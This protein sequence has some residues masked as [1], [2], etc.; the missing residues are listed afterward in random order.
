MHLLENHSPSE[1]GSRIK[2]LLSL[3]L[4]GMEN[5]DDDML[6]LL[7][8]TQFEEGV[9]HIK[10]GFNKV[11]SSLK[12]KQANP[13]RNDM[14]AMSAPGKAVYNSELNND[15]DCE[16]EDVTI[17]FRLHT[18]LPYP[19]SEAEW[20][21]IPK[22][23]TSPSTDKHICPLF[24]EPFRPNTLI[25]TH[26]V[27]VG[28]YM[29]II[30]DVEEKTKER[31]PS[32]SVWYRDTR[33]NND[34]WKL[35]P[36][37]CGKTTHYY[38]FQAND[39]IYGLGVF[40]DIE[41]GGRSFNLKCLDFHRLENGWLSILP[42][43]K[44]PSKW[45]VKFYVE[46]FKLEYATNTDSAKHARRALF[47]GMGLW[48]SY[49]FETNEIKQFE[50][51]VRIRL[52]CGGV[53]Y[54]DAIYFLIRDLPNQRAGLMAYTDPFIQKG[55]P[56]PV[57]GLENFKNALPVADSSEEFP[58]TNLL[59]MGEGR[60][61]IIWSNILARPVV[62]RI[63]CTKFNVH[64]KDKKLQALNVTTQVYDVNGRHIYS[65]HAHV[66]SD[67]MVSESPETDCT[68]SGG[69][70]KEKPRRANKKRNRKR[71]SKKSECA[72]NGAKASTQ[73]PEKGAKHEA[74][75]AAGNRSTQG[76]HSTH[77]VNPQPKPSKNE[78]KEEPR[79]HHLKPC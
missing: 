24:K 25:D 55:R 66:G 67:K 54:G 64:L 78:A 12:Q 38:F 47:F 44:E 31:I 46:A 71:K 7:E 22:C 56:T 42:F 23:H 15:T 77:R 62:T 41:N 14:Q 79:T 11:L 1:G 32:R 29:F 9:A 34:G 27:A 4:S 17:Y 20:F 28:P 73:G 30:S 10:K 75:E 43:S 40:E 74:Q 70:C 36:H 16:A 76:N 57:F 6:Q 68:H 53:G 33:D 65:L 18:P 35:A 72:G 2:Q 13:K 45:P 52:L 19:S 63:Y 39:K 26:P 49:N 50:G 61:C 37:L 8:R 60:L 5:I 48:I 3:V 58:P 51:H 69:Q 21:S 59:L